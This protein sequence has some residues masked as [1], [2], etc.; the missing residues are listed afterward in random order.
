MTPHVP[1]TPA[2]IV[3]Q[4][5]DAAELGASMVHLHAREP[6]NGTPTFRKEIYKEIIVG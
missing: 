2:E 6:G 5:L 4:V 1:V 3:A